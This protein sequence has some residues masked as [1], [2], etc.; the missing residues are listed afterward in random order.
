[1][2]ITYDKPTSKSSSK[3]EVEFDCAAEGRAL[4][5]DPRPLE[6]LK[7][8]DLIPDIGYCTIYTVGI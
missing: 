4:E 7:D 2:E 5:G 8:C 1:M 3:Y 6:V